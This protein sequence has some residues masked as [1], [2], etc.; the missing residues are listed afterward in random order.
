M[1]GAQTTFF[2]IAL[3]LEHTGHGSYSSYIIQ[4]GAIGALFNKMAQAQANFIS[5]YK[6]GV[7]EQVKLNSTCFVLFKT[8]SSRS[9][10]LFLAKINSYF[11]SGPSLVVIAVWGFAQLD[12]PG[13]C[14]FTFIYV[15]MCVCTCVNKNVIDRF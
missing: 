6:S 3:D 2:L 15:C 14:V 5:S 12:V 9:W 7:E 1:G 13:A 10:R 4:V 8:G 11:V